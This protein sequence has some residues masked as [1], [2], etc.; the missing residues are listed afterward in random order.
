MVEDQKLGWG[1]IGMPNTMNV[2]LT[3]AKYGLIVVGNKDLLVEDE[4]WKA[5]VQF[6]ERNGLVAHAGSPSSGSDHEDAPTD[7]STLTRLEKVTAGRERFEKMSTGP[8]WD[9]LRQIQAD[10][11]LSMTNP[12]DYDD[13]TA[14]D[15][16]DDDATHG[17]Y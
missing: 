10:G 3:R 14:Y 5:F 1:I 2:A 7:A 4:N 8:V 15:D 12:Y 9:L 6:C 11:E 17:G 16:D 13:D